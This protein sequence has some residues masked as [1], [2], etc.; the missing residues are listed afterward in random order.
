MRT[1]QTLPTV[2]AQAPAHATRVAPGPRVTVSCTVAPLRNGAEVVQGTLVVQLQVIPAGVL[3]IEPGA[4]EFEPPV[5]VS[6]QNRSNCAVTFLLAVMV[7]EQLGL[8]PVQSP[9]HC[10]KPEGG[11][12]AGVASRLT[13]APAA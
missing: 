12:L 4:S 6:V 13:T 10:L 9:S 2:P 7:S 3:A 8:V 5:T 11:G 1:V